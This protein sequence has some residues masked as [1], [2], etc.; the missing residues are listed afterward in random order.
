MRLLL[1]YLKKEADIL[2]KKIS[3]EIG[4]YSA[5]RPIIGICMFI[6][7]CKVVNKNQ[8]KD[9]S[10]HIYYERYKKGINNISYILSEDTI[11]KNFARELNTGK[12]FFLLY[13]NRF[14]YE[15]IAISFNGEFFHPAKTLNNG[16]PTRKQK[17][18]LDIVNNDFKM[19][20]FSF[21]DLASFLSDDIVAFKYCV[22]NWLISILTTVA[23]YREHFNDDSSS[24]PFALC[25]MFVLSM[26][27]TQVRLWSNKFYLKR[28]KDKMVRYQKTNLISHDNS[29]IVN[30]ADILKHN[31][32]KP[33]QNEQKIIDDFLNKKLVN[34]PTMIVQ[35]QHEFY[36]KKLSSKK[37]YKILEKI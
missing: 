12:E 11:Q 23:I 29:S 4:F 6:T 35:L 33:N 16:E 24:M 28:H 5:V 36:D 1:T 9:D 37:I 20:K 17:R 3:R 25:L 18:Y 13:A 7:K 30:L 19:T 21:I 22:I 2:F 8:H 15:P 10:Y 32:N 14:D 27:T 26:A 31:K 34:D